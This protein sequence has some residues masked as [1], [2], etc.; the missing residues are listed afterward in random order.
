MKMF[1]TNSLL[2]SRS[3][4]KHSSSLVM[5]TMGQHKVKPHPNAYAKDLTYIY[6]GA[7]INEG[8]IAKVEEHMADALKRGATLVTGGKRLSGAGFISHLAA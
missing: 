8:G 6:P 3:L 4:L 1:T 5:L 7:M 2:K